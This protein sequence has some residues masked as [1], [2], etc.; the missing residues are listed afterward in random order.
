MARIPKSRVAF[1][2]EKLERNKERDEE[3]IGL[4]RKL[5][6]RVLVIWECQMKHR[7]LNEV[8]TMIRAFLGDEKGG[9]GDEIR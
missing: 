6:W 1:W 3:A 9:E 7:E 2:R 5:G 8:A 4:L